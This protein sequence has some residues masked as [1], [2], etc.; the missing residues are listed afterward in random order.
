ML[1]C[2]CV[3]FGIVELY[4]ILKRNTGCIIQCIH[5]LNDCIFYENPCYFQRVYRK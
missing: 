3:A 4:L 5:I 1:L 2:A